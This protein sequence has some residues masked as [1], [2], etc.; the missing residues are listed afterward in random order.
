MH[1]RLMVHY[2]SRICPR[3]LVSCRE[4]WKWRE[5]GNFR[6]SHHHRFK[7]LLGLR[8]DP[9]NKGL[10]T[11]FVVTSDLPTNR[12]LNRKME[13]L[14]TPRKVRNQGGIFVLL[15]V[16]TIF[17]VSIPRTSQF[18][19]NNFTSSYLHSNSCKLGISNFV[20]FKCLDVTVSSN[21]FKRWADG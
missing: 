15:E 2:Q 16:M 9:I 10:E 5:K 17:N 13:R 3:R 8:R 20:K 1:K 4:Y 7:N 18:E 21:S 11:G 12:Y 6:A 14:V 19:N